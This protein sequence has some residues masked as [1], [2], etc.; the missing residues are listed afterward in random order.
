MERKLFELKPKVRSVK[1]K[2]SKVFRLV[3]RLGKE[4]PIVSLPVPPLMITL[5]KPMNLP[6]NACM[7]ARVEAEVY[8][9]MIP[10]QPK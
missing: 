10:K 1:E 6:P 2:A 8:A 4:D 9:R 3:S 5:S 7:H